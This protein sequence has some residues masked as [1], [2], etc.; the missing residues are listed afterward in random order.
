MRSPS[1]AIR[2]RASV[3][4][5]PSLGGAGKHERILVRRGLPVLH[6]NPCLQAP[7]SPLAGPGSNQGENRG[8][9]VRRQP[10]LQYPRAPLS[11]CLHVPRAGINRP[12]RFDLGQPLRVGR[13]GIR[14]SHRDEL[15]ELPPCKRF[16]FTCLCVTPRGIQ[17]GDSYVVR[18]IYGNSKVLQRRGE[19]LYRGRDQNPLRLCLQVR[20]GSKP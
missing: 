10:I 9:G 16:C 13:P 7:A 17:S 20:K 4:S 19:G 14:C 2:P 11:P 15:Y 18:I 6:L 5:S 3:R 8:R 1:A 12:V